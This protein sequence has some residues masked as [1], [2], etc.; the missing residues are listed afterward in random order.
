MK[1]R[2]LPILLLLAA[3]HPAGAGPQPLAEAAPKAPARTTPR[4][5]ALSL[6]EA[7]DLAF[8]QNPDLTAAA[9]RIGEAEA[10]VV[11][12]D[13]GFYPRV[14]ARVDYLYSNNP[15]LA[16]SSIVSQRRFNFGMNINEPGWVSNFR[17][18]IVGSYNLYR[19][20]QDAYLKKAA[21]LGVQA[22]ELEKSALRNRLA[23]AVTGAY[24]AVL[25]APRQIAVAHRSVETVAREL[26]L[27]RAR[28]EEGTALKADVLSLEVRAHEAEESELR[29]KNALTVAKSALK[30]LLGGN[31]LDLPEVRETEVPV[32]TLAPDFRKLFERARTQRPELQ[33][34]AH[35]I[36]IR[37]QE[38]AAAEGANYPRV[39]A[40]AAYG[41]NN[42]YPGF[43]FDRDNGTIGINAEL[44]LYTGGANSA[45]IQQAERRLAEARAIEQKATLEIEDE[46]RRA[47][48]TLDEALQRMKVAEA[49]TASAEEALRLVNEQ[50]HGGTA[51]VTRY[52]EAETDRANAALRAI[53]ARYE[54]QVADAQVQKALGQWR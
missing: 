11:E 13:A 19:G 9:A 3:A 2:L 30:A 32:P 35:Q 41:A 17:P 12:A 44:D 8:E 52:L 14:T 15:S 26:E 37:Q 24:Y 49:A 20:G 23:A 16:F 18:E 34:A 28:V 29:A 43:S 50:Y 42:R 25:T 7:I 22:A 36:Q 47:Y 31:G 48:S 21:E 4:N 1:P 54:T 33:A 39:N 27:T 40:Y 53:V 10:K 51:T 45:R 46:L 6:P 38:L 5:P